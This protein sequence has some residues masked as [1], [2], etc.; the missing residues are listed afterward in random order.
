MRHRG[1]GSEGCPSDIVSSHFLAG[2][3]ARGMVEKVFQHL[4]RTTGDRWQTR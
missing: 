2:K 3:R 1:L 4:L